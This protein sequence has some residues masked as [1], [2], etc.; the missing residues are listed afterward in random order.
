MRNTLYLPE[1]RE[2]LA[3]GDAAGL[4]EF[5]TA[6]H[7]ARTAEFMEGLDAAEVWEVLRHA[8]PMRRAEI[9]SFLEQPRQVEMLE[10]LDPQEMAELVADLAHDDRVDILQDAEP[11]TVE[12]LLPLVPDEERRDILRLSAYPEDTAGAIMTSEYAR[13]N[14]DDTIDAAVEAITRSLREGDLQT[15]NYL[16]VVD[17]ADHLRGVVSVAQLL[18]ALAK[19]AMQ[20]GDIM[21]QSVVSVDVDADQEKVAAEV[22]RYDFAAIP[23]VDAEH[24]MLGV[25]THDDVIDVVREEAVEDAQRIGAVDPLE[26]TYLETSLL[27]LT[28]KRGIWLIILFFG[29]LLTAIALRGYEDRLAQWAWLV[30]FIPLVISSGGNSGSQ[31][32]TLIISALAAGH[33]SLTDWSRIVVRELVQG[34]LL[35]AFLGLIGYGAARML[36]V[37]S[38]DAAVVPITLLLVVLCGTL[39]G[40]LLP[41]LFRRL[42]FDP[43]IMS[44]PF[45]AGIIDLVGIVIY[46][47][48]ASRLLAA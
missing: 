22:A 43:A 32:A 29:A 1:L 25:I 13:L 27:T 24:H 42:G 31:S 9:F 4:G 39:T 48:V 21:N 5:C 34:I 3:E 28:W 12:E 30:L 6:I 8:E 45:V 36:G 11:Q 20:I 23:V 33:I 10:T 44:T 17:K 2:M 26:E 37:A 47:T 15:I 14:E 38:F 40:S 46:M 16:Y 7:P 41:L 19:P 18:S 35:G